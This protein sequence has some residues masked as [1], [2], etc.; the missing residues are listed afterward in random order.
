MSSGTIGAAM[1]AALSGTRAIAVSYGIVSHPSP[2]EFVQP[3]HELSC[4][5]IQSLYN[6]WGT[7]DESGLVRSDLELYSVNVPLVATIL[8]TGDNGMQVRWTTLWRNSYAR[9]F[10]PVIL[11]PESAG[12][13]DDPT[14][15]GGTLAF[16]WAPSM[17]GLLTPDP[18][19]LPV[20]SG[21]CQHFLHFRDILIV[22]GRCLRVCA[23]TCLYYPTLRQLCRADSYTE[24]RGQGVEDEAVV[25][26]YR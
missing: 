14:Q 4:R 11:S 19:S 20:Q 8:E 5:I 9:L 17:T 23:R 2:P 3:A 22:L 25:Q 1:S 12:P 26:R 24:G 18:T 15:T 7:T 16:Q 10:R 6:Q 21:R 13:V